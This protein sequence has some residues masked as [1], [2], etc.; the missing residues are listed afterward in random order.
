M[1]STGVV[2]REGE[3]QVIT[4]GTPS[5]KDEKVQQELLECSENASRFPLIGEL[6]G[7]WS[8]ISWK[9]VCP[10]LQ[11]K[12]SSHIFYICN[13]IFSNKTKI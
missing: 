3:K 9:G 2:R 8:L 10:E 1:Y 13:I 12:S 5:L 7:G 4:N 6:R 11:L